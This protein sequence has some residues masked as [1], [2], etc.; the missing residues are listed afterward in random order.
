MVVRW[1]FG[2]GIL[3]WTSGVR[4]KNKRQVARRSF[5]AKTAFLL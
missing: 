5:R 4:Q 3:G 2:F 1:Q